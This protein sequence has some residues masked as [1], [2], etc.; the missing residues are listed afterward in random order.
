MIDISRHKVLCQRTHCFHER[1]TALQKRTHGAFA[2]NRGVT[3]DNAHIYPTALHR[4]LKEKKLFLVFHKKYTF[5]RL[6][7]SIFTDISPHFL[8]IDKRKNKYFLDF[9]K[10]ISK[11]FFEVL[12]R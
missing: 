1:H 6:L 11:I 5:P 8:Q 12:L 2:V 10:N 3:R 9:T 4:F 7:L